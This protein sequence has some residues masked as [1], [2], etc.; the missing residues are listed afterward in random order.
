MGPNHGFNQQQMNP[1]MN[2]NQ[3]PPMR[4]Q[5]LQRQLSQGNP[6]Q[7][8]HMNPYQGQGHF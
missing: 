5:M 3:G 8:P 1:Q 7:Q 2:A 4:G 6:Q